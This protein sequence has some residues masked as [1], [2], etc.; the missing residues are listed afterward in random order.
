MNKQVYVVWNNK[1][2]VGKSTIVFHLAARYAE[3]NPQRNIL[4]L[5][6]CP[7][8]NSTMMFLGGGTSGEDRLLALQEPTIPKTIVGY[9]T[10]Q[11]EKASG[12]DIANLDRPY[13][14]VK[15]FNKNMP[16]KFMANTRRW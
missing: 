10:S 13:F 15:D 2:G 5:D 4:V 16:E 1:G 14:H 8:A 7:Q 6:L 11:I 9:L 3:L 12:G